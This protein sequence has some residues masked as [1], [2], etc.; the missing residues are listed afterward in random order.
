MSLPSLTLVHL[1]TMNCILILRKYNITII[2]HMHIHK[3]ALTQILAIFVIIIYS[4][5]PVPLLRNKRKMPLR[6]N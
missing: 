6:T 2:V 4:C 3:V 1:H 5:N